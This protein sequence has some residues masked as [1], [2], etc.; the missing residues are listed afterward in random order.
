MSVIS[1]NG[2][3]YYGNSISI[4]N[5]KVY[6]DGKVSSD[7]ND[8]VITISV[9]GDLDSIVADHCNKIEIRGNVR[10]I[11]NSS[12]DISISD[13]VLGDVSTQSGDIECGDVQGNVETQSGDV[14]CGI[15]N[16]SV[17]T[18]TGDIKNKK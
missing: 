4:T 10:I 13:K 7:E 2:K 8:K 1:I 11:K 14:K 5:G 12:G 15:V 9:D 18:V 3:T 6:I 16:G 17:S